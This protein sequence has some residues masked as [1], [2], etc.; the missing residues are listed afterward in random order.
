MISRSVC[1]VVKYSK[2]I[3][4]RF[5]DRLQ[6][7]LAGIPFPVNSV[8]VVPLAYLSADEVYRTKC[9]YANAKQILE[10]YNRKMGTDFHIINLFICL[11][12]CCLF[13]DVSIWLSV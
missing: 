9:L 11:F 5:I 10:Q 2:D 4:V 1:F 7:T 13:P 8:G 6:A 3:I 12:I